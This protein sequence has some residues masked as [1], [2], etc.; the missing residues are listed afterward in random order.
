[1]QH[2]VTCPNCGAISAAGQRF[3]GKGGTVLVAVPQQVPTAPVQQMPA[4][5]VQQMPAA[6]AQEMPA[7][8]ASPVIPRQQVEV[9][10][11]WGL[12]WGLL[13]RMVVLELLIGGIIYLIV[14]MVMVLAFNYQFPF[15]A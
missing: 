6:P 13:W 15:G 11:T 10:P 12:A 4:A 5:P 14:A 3:C 8:V 9:K 2:T 1:M 7:K